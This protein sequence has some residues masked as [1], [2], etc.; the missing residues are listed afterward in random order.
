MFGTSKVG[1]IPSKFSGVAGQVEFTSPGDTTWVVPS[2][3][4]SVSALCI[5]AGSSIF[6]GGGGGGL[7][8]NTF[9]VTP[10]ETLTISVPAPATSTGIACTISRGATVLLRAQSAS[11]NIGGAADTTNG[12]TSYAVGSTTG[13]QNYRGGGG[14]AGYAGN[15]GNG[16]AGGNPGANGTAG[17]GGGGGGG[18]GGTSSIAAGGG[19][20]TG[21][22]GQGTSGTGGI[23]STGTR[24]GNGGSGG[25]NGGEPSGFVGGTG[26]NF[27]GGRGCGNTTAATA[28]TGA[29]RIIW[30]AGRAYP[31]TNTGNV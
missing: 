28:G 15:G 1:V 2:G 16:G 11:G 4:T 31:S 29:V 12:A 24:K 7:S 23:N 19:G 26:G 18:A 22:Y 3:V 10:G 14:A 13:T 6:S 30:G 21:I 17:T 5:G 8:Y 27:G 25:A 20:G 9:A